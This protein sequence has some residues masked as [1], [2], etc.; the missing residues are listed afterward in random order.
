L[1]PSSTA[2]SFQYNT[3][4]K[5]ITYKQQLDTNLIGTFEEKLVYF[6]KYL[7]YGSSF[8]LSLE[9]PDE[10]DPFDYHPMV[11]IVNSGWISGI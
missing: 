6:K 7:A 2:C 1:V 4:I 3:N 10:L 8:M 9:M 5:S 11:N